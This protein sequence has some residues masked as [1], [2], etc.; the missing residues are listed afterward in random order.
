MHYQKI[1]INTGHFL[2]CPKSYMIF[3]NIREKMLIIKE[4]PFPPLT[5]SISFKD[6][7]FS[8]WRLLLSKCETGSRVEL[9]G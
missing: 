8:S 6:T 4:F 3:F 5:I 1:M 9:K 2:C 7:E